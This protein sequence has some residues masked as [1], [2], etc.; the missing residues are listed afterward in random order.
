MSD[1]E[2]A[3]ALGEPVDLL[4]TGASGLLG[5]ALCECGTGVEPVPTIAGTVRREVAVP[6]PTVRLDLSRQTLPE[7]PACRAAILCASITAAAE[8][9]ADP[10]EAWFV[11]V[12]QTL[13]VA[14][15]L[16][17]RG[18]FVVFPSTNLVFD[19][20]TAFPLPGH[21]PCPRTLYG[22]QKAVVEQAL[23]LWPMRCAVARITKVV[24]P[25]WPLLRRW[26]ETWNA[27]QP[28]RAFNDYRFSPVPL[29]QVVRALR[30]LA[31]ERR[32]GTWHLSGPRDV[33]YAEFARMVIGDRDGTGPYRGGEEIGDRDGAGPYR[34]V[35]ESCAGRVEWNPRHTTLNTVSVLWEL[36]EKFP[37][38][39]DVAQELML[40]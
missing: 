35:E 38:P 21:R 6:V 30:K 17:E 16:I 9:A 39:E 20:E 1:T 4:V 19:G 27:G 14:R 3:L 24:S 13:N 25:D 23:L 37:S 34:V 36:R 29:T 31:L 26:A 22:W 28:V 10:E 18:T 5:R 11:N 15:A 33:S 40:F 8:L 2:K 7:L 12:V 32:A